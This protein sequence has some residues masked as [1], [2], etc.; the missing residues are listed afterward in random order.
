MKIGLV[1]DGLAEMDLPEAL[2]WTVSRGIEAV[3]IGTGGF[4][5]V[6]HCQLQELLASQHARDAFMGA[7]TSRNLMLS[8]LNCNGNPLD[9]DDD[10]RGK[11][12][13]ELRHT[14]EVASQLGIDTVV[15]MSGCPG[16]P[17]GG[18]YPNW[19]THP[20]QP[21]FAELLNWQ[22][23]QCVTPYWRELGTFAADHGVKIA[24]EAHPGQV[25]YNTRTLLRLREIV[26][27]QLGANLDPSHF[28]YQG[29]DAH[30]AIRYLGSGSVFHVHA[31]DTCIDPYETALT[32]TLDT[33]PMLDIHERAWAYRTLGFGHDELW[34]RKFVSA[35]QQVG[36]D[37][38][39]SI[40][41]EDP[42]MSSHE[43]IEKSVEFLKPILLRTQPDAV[44]PWMK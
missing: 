25:V 22:W 29:I 1:M 28:F 16:T 39:L 31:K 41:H 14:I 32:G 17:E 36:Y 30:Q 6:P 12:Q 9:P 44:P 35:L 13:Q 2:D 43:G 42:V 23:E 33:R 7:I 20:W 40:E 19:V 24:I 38:A 3:E 5:P 4:S 21:E 37:G 34:W 15:T 27:P 10:R 18:G 26:G 8:A 11:T